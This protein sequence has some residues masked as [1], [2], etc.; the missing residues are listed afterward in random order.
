M[1]SFFTVVA[2]SVMTIIFSSA[3]N[4]VLFLFDVFVEKKIANPIDRTNA[5]VIAI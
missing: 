2:S 1:G 5:I 4:L 3:I